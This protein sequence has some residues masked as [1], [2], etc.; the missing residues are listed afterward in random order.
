MKYMS[1]QEASNKWQISERRVLQYCKEGR[2]DGVT[3]FGRAWAIP[4]E[5]TKPADP[6]KARKELINAEQERLALIGEGQA[7]IPQMRV[8]ALIVAAGYFDEDR[9]VS[10]FT[11]LGAISL[12]RRIVLNFQ[13]AHISP[14]VVVTGYQA[15]ELEH[16]LSDYGCIFV[17]NPDYRTTDKLASAKLGFSFLMDKCDKIFLASLTI[18]MFMAETLWRMAAIDKPLV[19]PRF[20]ETEGHP[21]LLDKSLIPGILDYHG[22]GG[23]REALKEMHCERTFLEVEDRGVLLSAEHVPRLNGL[24]EEHNNQLLHPFL[25]LSIEKDK[26][27]FDGRGKL[28]LFLLR[29]VH[30]ISAACKQM[31]LSRSKALSMID[32]ME[33]AVG[34][35]LVK[36]RQGGRREKRT[37]LTPAGEAFLEFYMQYEKSVVEYAAQEFEVQFAAFQKRVNKHNK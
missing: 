37:A 8:G 5:T 22:E 30:S 26:L 11:N 20:E 4:I 6:R 32:R 19:L 27:F 35:P 1:V 2:I 33:E 24:L 9:G 3:R 16:H 34:L 25:R 17:H 10:P 12:I 29:E 36:R 13:K 31:A 28:L 14:I 21:P 15:L 7:F 18:P 23:I